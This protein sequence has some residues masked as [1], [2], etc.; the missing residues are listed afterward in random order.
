MAHIGISNSDSSK[1]VDYICGG[2]LIS[3]NFVLTAAH[4]SRKGRDAV[5]MVRLNSTRDDSPGRIY[6]KIKAFRQHEKYHESN[7]YDVALIEL[8]EPVEFAAG[9]L[10]PACLWTSDT[11]NFQNAIVTG[12]GSTDFAGEGSK[13]LMK[14]QVDLV[15]L[16]QCK[17]AMCRSYTKNCPVNDK[18]HICNADLN[19]TTRKDACQGG[20]I[21]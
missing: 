6:R 4:C 21:F 5:S 7:H 17:K 20:N 18:L 12:W 15:N 16:D 10:R 13:I 9:G 8:D 3:E 19:P 1:S 2:T 11:I 14:A